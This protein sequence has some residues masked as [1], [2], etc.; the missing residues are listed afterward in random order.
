MPDRPAL[1]ERIDDLPLLVQHFVE[2]AGR[3]DFIFP[4]SLLAK[5]A[6]FD[7]PGNVRQ[8]RN[9]VD[10][11]LALGRTA[12]QLENWSEDEFSRVLAIQAAHKATDAEKQRIMSALEQC[13]GN[14]TLAAKMLGMAR[15]TLASR[16]DGY[17]MTRPRKSR[18]S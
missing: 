7:W 17:R 11:L 12:A 15:N 18:R 6:T 1:R 8:L 4:E 14:Q 9:V 2:V 13:G 16:L 3:G 10:R 5:L